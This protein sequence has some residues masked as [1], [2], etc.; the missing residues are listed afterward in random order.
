MNQ[1]FTIKGSARALP[2]KQVLSAELDA[3]LGLRTGWTAEHTGVLRRHQCSGPDEARE[4]TARVCHAALAD[5]GMSLRQ[6]DLIVDASLSVQQPIPCNAALVQEALGAEA[7]GIPG[8]DVHASCLGFVAAVNVVNGLFASGAVRSA[9]I[10]CAE[11]PLQGVNWNEPESAC[12]MGDAAA[13]HVLVAREATAPCDFVFETFAEGATLCEVKGGGHRRPP[14]G[15]SHG[16]EAAFRFHMDGKA[17]H[18]LASKRLPPMLQGL[19]Q[20][21]GRDLTAVDL[22]PH[23]A[24]GPALEFMRRRLGVPAERF[25]VSIADHGNLV[26]ASIPFVLDA[27]RRKL[28][29]GSPVLLVGTAAGYT[30]AAGL[31]VL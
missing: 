6:L 16:D 17:V 20:R 2:R 3:R 30:Q 15:Y 14:F 9:L 21:T 22:V 8:I 11:T 23:Q 19:F 18:R 7:R 1:Y 28:G 29:A 24:S 31:F 27:V 26:A 12:L 4:L 25:H 13:A 10:V 5:A